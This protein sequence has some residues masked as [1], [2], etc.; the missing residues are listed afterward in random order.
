MIDICDA[1]KKF[2]IEYM[3]FSF[4]NFAINSVFV[5]TNDITIII[6]IFCIVHT[7]ILQVLIINT[8][9][10]YLYQFIGTS[11]TVIIENSNIYS[12]NL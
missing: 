5:E 1:C 10:K 7:I 8:V 11:N 3:N 4:T 2:K 12:D 9:L 6:V